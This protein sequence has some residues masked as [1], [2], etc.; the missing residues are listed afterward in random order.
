[1]GVRR[2]SSVRKV[3]ST[4]AGSGKGLKKARVSTAS[5]VVRPEA[6]YQAS[7]ACVVQG[8]TSAPFGP[9]TRCSTEIAPPGSS[10]RAAA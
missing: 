4:T 10:T 5:A 1:M 8:L 6:K 9:S 2:S 7:A 3:T